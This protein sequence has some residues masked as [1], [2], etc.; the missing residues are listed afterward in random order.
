VLTPKGAIQSDVLPFA[1]RLSERPHASSTDVALP[2]RLTLDDAMT[3]Y[4]RASV[5][6]LDG[7]QSEAARVLGVARNTVAKAMKKP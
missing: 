1:R 3:R 6:A 5:R 7:N 2:I 4:I